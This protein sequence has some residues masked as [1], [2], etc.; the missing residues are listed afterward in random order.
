MLKLSVKYLIMYFCN[1][2]DILQFLEI[3]SLNHFKTEET[4][5]LKIFS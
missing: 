1:Y 4:G 5:I 3:F 2:V